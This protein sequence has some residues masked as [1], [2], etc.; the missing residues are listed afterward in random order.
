MNVMRK[1]G[2]VFLI[3]VLLLLTACGGGGGGNAPAGADGGGSTVSNGAYTGSTSPAIITTSNAKSL[4][5]AAYQNAQTAISVAALKS[6]AD[7]SLDA[8][9]AVTIAE[10]IEKD[11]VNVV[12]RQLQELSKTAVETV[13]LTTVRGYSGSLSF[14][15]AI[16]TATGVCT[17]SFIYQGYVA[18]A[19]YPPITGAVEFDGI[20]NSVTGSFNSFTVKISD[21]VTTSG[22]S[23]V[24]L[25]G[26]LSATKTGSTK[27]ITISAVLTTSAGYKSQVKN[28]EVAVTNSSLT[29]KGEFYDS[30]HGYVILT[31]LAPVSLPTPTSGQI[32]VAG[33]NNTKARLTFNSTGYVVEF[34]SG[35]GVW[36][37]V[38]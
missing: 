12:T 24:A 35:N 27:T 23:Q 32:L 17:G 5:T 33:A 26:R 28:Y 34:D 1:P 11:A 22:S 21:L 20:F 8:P 6:A 2:V 3:G 19:G 16:D 13:P 15:M 7:A 31:T 10:I 25:N 4:V 38:N 18:A 14:T 9:V 36:A 30:T 37:V 29:M